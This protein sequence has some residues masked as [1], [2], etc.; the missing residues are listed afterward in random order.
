VFSG[1][2]PSQI[3][4]A[5]VSPKHHHE[6]AEGHHAHLVSLPDG[7]TIE[8]GGATIKPKAMIPVPSQLIQD[9]GVMANLVSILP[10][11]LS[12]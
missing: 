4:Y 9:L 8:P 2:T 1:N 3:R 5:S 7:G 11:Q 12:F 10:R 6:M